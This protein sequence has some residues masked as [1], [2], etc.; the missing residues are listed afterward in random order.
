MRRHWELVKMAV[1]AAFWRA[2][3]E[4][5]VIGVH[6]LAV[7]VAIEIAVFVALDYAPAAQF[8]EYGLGLTIGYTLLELAVSALVLRPE[9]RI[10]V[11]A[12]LTVSSTIL[13]AALTAL[14][15]GGDLLLRAVGATEWM[16][17]AAV[18]FAVVLYVVWVLGAFA[19]MLRSFH[20]DMRWR[21]WGRAGAVI[22]AQLAVLV[23]FPSYPAFYTQDT[24]DDPPNF[25]GYYR[26]LL[27]QTDE[28]A[29]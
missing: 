8:T 2:T 25:W 9:R 6:G 23:V 14:A 28:A 19:A 13:G 24:Q 22:G 3:A 29:R 27:G 1:R 11:C 26:A 17:V 12:V 5:P 16:R 20:A 15:A 7:W 4:P 18:A 10:D 21:G